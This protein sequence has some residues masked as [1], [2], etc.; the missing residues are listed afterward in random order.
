MVRVQGCPYIWITAPK[1]QPLLDFQQPNPASGVEYTVLDEAWTRLVSVT[2][3]V[4]WTVAP[5]FLALTLIVDG[6]TM[7]IAKIS[8]AHNT[9]YF[10]YR[11]A[12]GLLFFT[13]DTAAFFP[14]PL[15]E[16]RHV[17]VTASVTGGTVQ[18]LNV[19]IRRAR[20][21]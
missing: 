8:P 20:W 3:I 7:S 16:G 10:I 14:Y 15:D 9:S 17:K 19:L 11:T 4:Q 13:T 2:A 5:A 21:V 6:E 12:G 1:K 18:L